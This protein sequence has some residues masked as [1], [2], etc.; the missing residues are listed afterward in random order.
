MKRIFSVL[1]L[2]LVGLM[3]VPVSSALASAPPVGRALLVLDA[4]PFSTFGATADQMALTAN[5]VSFDVVTSTQLVSNVNMIFSY[6]LII[7]AGDQPQSYYN[8]LA[9]SGWLRLY[10][11]KFVE[12]GGNLVIHGVDEGYNGG[13][14][15]SPVFFPLMFNVGEVFSYDPTNYVVGSNPVLTGVSS[16]ISGNYASHDY[17]TSVPSN[18]LVL[19]T[20]SAGFPTYFVWT[21]AFGKVY[22]STMPLEYYYE[23]GG[24]VEATLL[25]NEI[26]YASH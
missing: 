13:F 15:T 21:L 12:G 23:T 5:G 3:L 16:P 22:A 10:L 24:G 19:I 2:L 7:F 1:A 18:A 4:S 20:N 17:F 9:T 14:W 26:Y 25:S 8:T 6:H 11:L